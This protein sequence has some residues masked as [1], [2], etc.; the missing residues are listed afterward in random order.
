MM[1]NEPISL[2]KERM[3]KDDSSGSWTPVEAARELLHRL[4]SGEL[5][6]EE[7][8]ITG[9]DEDRTLFGLKSQTT[10]ESTIALLEISKVEAF[11][12][13]YED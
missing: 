1:S 12:E 9:W 5:K 7:L 10:Y 6:L 4:E 8:I 2:A 3:R 13:W 11:R